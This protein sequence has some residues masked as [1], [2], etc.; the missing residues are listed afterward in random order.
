MMGAKKMCHVTQFFSNAL[1]K[2]GVLGVI[3]RLKAERSDITLNRGVR[4][5]R[6][7]EL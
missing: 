3:H 6:H 5:A 7:N 4:E 2:L 1:L